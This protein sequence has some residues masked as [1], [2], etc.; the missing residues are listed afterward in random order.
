M[1]EA[2]A[3]ASPNADSA[4]N[5]LAEYWMLDPAPLHPFSALAFGVCSLM[6]LWS[7]ATFHVVGSWSLVFRLLLVVLL[8]GRE[9]PQAFPV[10]F[11][12]GAQ[13]WSKPKP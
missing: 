7:F 11:R 9:S 2:P 3:A 6:F 12:P 1:V 13:L 5:A 10:G 8:V 4:S